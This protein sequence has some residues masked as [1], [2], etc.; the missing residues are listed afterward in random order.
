M[1]RRIE[2]KVLC[3]HIANGTLFYIERKQEIHL[4]QTILRLA[5]NEK[6]GMMN[7]SK[8]WYE[9]KGTPE[10]P[11]WEMATAEFNEEP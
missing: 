7:V 2:L 9:N 4:N 3:I 11:N 6:T 8:T 5:H 1:G 10:N